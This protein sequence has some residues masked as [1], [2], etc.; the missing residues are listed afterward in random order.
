MIGTSKYL[1]AVSVLVCAKEAALS[2]L[3]FAWPA[4]ASRY[5]LDS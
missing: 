4:L 2:V 5:S 3:G 1:D